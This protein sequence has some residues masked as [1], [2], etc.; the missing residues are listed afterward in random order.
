MAYNKTKNLIDRY[1][2]PKGKSKFII[3]Y[4]K[5]DATNKWVEYSLDLVELKASVKDADF[6]TRFDIERTIKKVESKIDWMYKH[7][8]FDLNEAVS[9][10]KRA[11]RLLK[12]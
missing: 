12:Y 10:Y 1:N 11:K 2:K 3:S 8:N 6:S 9:L 7:N 5:I 4:N